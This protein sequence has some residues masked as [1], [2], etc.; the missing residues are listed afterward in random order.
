LLP[1]MFFETR[2]GA[3]FVSSEKRLTPVDMHYAQREDEQITYHLPDGLAVEGAPKDAQLSWQGH[4]AY[5]TKTVQSPGSVTIARQI[6][7]AFAVA[8]PEEYQDLRGFYQ[9]VAATDQQQ[10][11]LT[12]QA[13]AAQSAKGN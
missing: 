6:A 9:K 11:V 10:L 8:K 1:G 3:N 4:A 2:R 13:N 12:T 7:R 5:G